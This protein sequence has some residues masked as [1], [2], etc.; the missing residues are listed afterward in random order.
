VREIDLLELQYLKVQDFASAPKRKAV[1]RRQYIYGR[2]RDAFENAGIWEF[3]VKGIPVA[4]YTRGGDPFEFDM[5]YPLKNELRLFHAVSLKTNVDAG[6]MLAARYPAI[7]AGMN[8]SR[9]VVPVLT[10]VV[11]D[12]LDKERD[13]IGFAL[14]M[15][16][17]NNIEISPVAEMP[18]I[19]ERA[20]QESGA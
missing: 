7:A 10:A 5:G 14:A 9:G 15:M 20:R 1:G 2:M 11:D 4:Q 6:V 8:A 19:A 16:K 12:G 17:E 18:M 13:E 3:L